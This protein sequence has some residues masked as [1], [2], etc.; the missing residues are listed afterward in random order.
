MVGSKHTFLDHGRF[1]ICEAALAE[2][3]A[4]DAKYSDAVKSSVDSARAGVADRSSDAHVHRCM[5]PSIRAR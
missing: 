3:V 5:P 2:R 4:I 1:A